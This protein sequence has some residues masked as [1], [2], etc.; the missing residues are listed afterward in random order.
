[1]VQQLLLFDD[2]IPGYSSVQLLNSCSLQV[3]VLVKSMR[4]AGATQADL[5]QPTGEM[6]GEFVQI[7][8]SY[9]ELLRGV[10]SVRSFQDL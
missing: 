1:M 9:Y 7:M 8:K 6:P 4:A 5:C 10:L 3:R 2:G